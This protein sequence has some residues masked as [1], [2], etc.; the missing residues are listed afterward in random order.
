MS[1][2][3]TPTLIDLFRRLEARLEGEPDT[4]QGEIVSGAYM[5][6]PQPRGRHGAAQ[7]N[8]FAELRAR[9]GMS[10]VGSRPPDWLFIIEPEIRSE[11]TFSRVVPDVAGWRRSSSGW[12]DLDTTP[13]SLIPDWV[14][15]VLSPS[16][17]Q[18]DRS[19]KA[20]A[21]GAMAVGWLW[22]LDTDRRT[23]ETF[24]NIRGRMTPGP[25]FAA[26]H[27]ATGDPFGPI[28]VPVD[29]IFV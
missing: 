5:M 24:A 7:G 1:A 15:E 8:L 3:P 25:V 2:E 16:T 21:H 14:G 12:P 26:G 29:P 20:A 4:V 18:S 19:E 27:Q 22:L 11:R 9:F 23:I 28:P 13:I 6:S 17:E 10:T